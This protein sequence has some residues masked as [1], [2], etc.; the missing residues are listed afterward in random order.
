MCWIRRAARSFLRR[1]RTSAILPR[2]SKVFGLVY[3]GFRALRSCQLKIGSLRS[4]RCGASPYS[5]NL[6]L[7]HVIPRKSC[8]RHPNFWRFDYHINLGRRFV[9]SQLPSSINITNEPPPR[10]QQSTPTPQAYYRI[11]HRHNCA[12]IST[13]PT[14]S[15]YSPL[16]GAAA[17][18]PRRGL[19]VATTTAFGQERE[20]HLLSG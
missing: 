10:Q 6:S 20:D 8:T 15:V 14:S 2:I 16:V 19:T 1:D 4:L 13:S 5:A 11:H 7:S 18:D 17:R 9:A 12:T 3:I